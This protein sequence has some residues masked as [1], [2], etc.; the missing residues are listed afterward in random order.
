MEINW[1]DYEEYGD[2]SKYN[3]L[4]QPINERK[5]NN[6]GVWIPGYLELCKK[7]DGDLESKMDEMR[8]QK[9]L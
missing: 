1:D 8:L 3:P 4:N 6:C 5:C 9:R 7:C 2:D